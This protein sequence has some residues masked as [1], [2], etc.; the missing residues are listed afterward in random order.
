MNLINAAMSTT[1]P[2]GYEFHWA[3]GQAALVVFKDGNVLSVIPL[4]KNT[5]AEAKRRG[6]KL[7]AQLHIAEF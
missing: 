1:P 7:M 6:E 5:E 3:T 4:E 2:R